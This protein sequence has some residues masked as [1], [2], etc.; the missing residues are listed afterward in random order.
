MKV[1][2]VRPIDYCIGKLSMKSNFYFRR[3]KYGKVFVQRCPRML[4][5]KQQ[6]WNQEFA[7]RYACRHTPPQA[8]TT[9]T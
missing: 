2:F 7:K 8:I 5:E 1:T 3:N 9:N 4:S 6:A